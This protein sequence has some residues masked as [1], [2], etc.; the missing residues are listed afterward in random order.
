VGLGTARAAGD[1][2]AKAADATAP[3]AYCEAM[4]QLRVARAGVPRSGPLIVDRDRNV[5]K[6]PAF[7]QARDAS[8]EVRLW[9]REFS[10]TPSSRPPPEVEHTHLPAERRPS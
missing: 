10:L 9:A 4:A 5:P 3:A 1:G 6:N 8:N 2:T 7:P